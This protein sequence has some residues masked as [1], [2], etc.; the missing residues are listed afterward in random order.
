[1]LRRLMASCALMAL[2]ALLAGC[3]ATQQAAVPAPTTT[4]TA[5]TAADAMHGGGHSGTTPDSS[6]PY[7]A[8]FIDSM[9]EHHQGAIAMANQALKEALST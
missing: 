8:Q 4:S 9:I 6:A 2:I 7:D 3:G 1:M 5:P